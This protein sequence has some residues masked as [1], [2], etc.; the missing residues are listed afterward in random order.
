M[1]NDLL[2]SMEI[3]FEDAWLLIVNKPS[4]LPTQA[5][6]DPKRPNLYTL[7]LESKKWKYIGMHHRLDTPTS[8]IVLFTKDRSANKGVSL[9]FQEHQIQKKYLSLINGLPKESS[10]TIKNHLK[11]VKYKN[12][13]TKMKSTLSGG[14][15][16]HTDFTVLE[17]YESKQTSLLQAAPQTGR[18][19][20][21]RVH[22]AESQFPILGD[23]LYFRADRHYPRLLLH[24]SELH[25]QHPMTKKSMVIT[26]T[27]PEDFKKVI[28]MFSARI[29]EGE[30]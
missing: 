6:L 25:F 1:V 2:P 26:T 5:T 16:A 4:G 30:D 18:M 11:S 14:D 7:L 19:H 9:L 10:F 21:I 3:L 13:K 28:S 17:R 23:S 27:L 12:G 15:F 8:G 24:A 22:L 29:S 20:Q